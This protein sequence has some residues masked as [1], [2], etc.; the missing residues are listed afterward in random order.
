M[1]TKFL[2]EPTEN[3]IESTER[4]AKKYVDFEEICEERKME[5]TPRRI[6]K[7]PIKINLSK[8][9]ERSSQMVKTDRKLQKSNSNFTRGSR[10]ARK[11]R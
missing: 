2:A 4:R 10:T 1:L 5:V 3:Q 11:V 9:R 8:V 6:K 7:K